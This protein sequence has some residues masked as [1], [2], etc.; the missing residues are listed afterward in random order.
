VGGDDGA[1]SGD[2]GQS[3]PR[4]GSFTITINPTGQ[5]GSAGGGAG[6]GGYTTISW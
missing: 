1:Y 6:S 4:N 5:G 2:N 3:F